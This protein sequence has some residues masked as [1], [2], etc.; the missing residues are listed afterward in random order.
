VRKVV[1]FAVSVAGCVATTPPGTPGDSGGP[2]TSAPLPQ[3]R[4][5]RSHTCALDVDGEAHC[6]GEGSGPVP[7]GGNQPNFDYGQGRLPPGSKSVLEVGADHT[8]WLDEVGA[9]GCVGGDSGL[10]GLIGGDGWSGLSVGGWHGCAWRAD[11]VPSC[12]G[13]PNGD[14]PRAPFDLTAPP[15]GAFVAL[16]GGGWHHCGL[17]SDD[18]LECWGYAEDGQL[19]VPAGS[20]TA[21]SAG[22]R[23]TCA[24]DA[25]GAVSCWG[26]SPGRPPPGSF[27][28]VTAGGSHAC[29][30]DGSGSVTCWGNA[31][32]GRTA[33]PAERFSAVSAG[34]YHTCG[35]TVDGGIRCWGQSD[36]GQA[37]VPAEV[38]AW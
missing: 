35:V 15:A 18:T 23:Q 10:R 9:L 17:R 21:V 8:C 19:A 22:E 28:Q 26:R 30:L 27:V 32:D 37:D 4:C 16:D 2:A 12:W 13:N 3:V 25:T 20:W 24:L 5:G 36:Y 11:G 31:D 33:P 14:D 34:W 38:A 1:V 7:E 6:W 29:A